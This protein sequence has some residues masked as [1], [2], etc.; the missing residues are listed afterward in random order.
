MRYIIDLREGDNIA[1]HYLCKQKQIL[2]SRAGKS[3]ISLKLQDKT[4]IIDGKVW[5]LGD[6]IHEFSDYDFI[7]V[8]ATVL[9]YQGEPQLN[10]RRIRKSSEGEYDPK[11]YIPSTQKDIN[12]MYEQLLAY[13]PTIENPY[14][15]KLI[16]SFLVEDEKF[17]KQFKYHSAAKNIHHSYMGGLLEHTLAVVEICD[18][19]STRYEGVNRDIVIAT[20]IFHDIGKIQELSQFP[21]N[22]YTDD[23]QLIGHL[24]MGMEMVS[25]KIETISGF[26]STL[27]SLIKHSLL[28]HHGE[29][30]YGSPK[31][32]KTIEAF[33][34]HAADNTDAKIKIIEEAISNEAKEDNWIGYQ[35]LFN[36]NLRRT[37]F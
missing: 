36:R 12:Q 7:K 31:R 24:I 1:E 26:P 23:G 33:I 13:I 17:I 14:I 3:Y 29:L 20:A 18:F 21:E 2:K 25:R 6:G 32:P 11:D 30:E 10:I 28:S 8:D 27:A 22:D 9:L 5:D 19:L 34:L 15:K 16:E 35:K 4:G 37:N